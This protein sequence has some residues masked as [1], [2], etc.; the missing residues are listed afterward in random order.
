MAVPITEVMSK[1]R[2]IESFMLEARFCHRHTTER[3]GGRGG[4]VDEM[5]LSMG[6]GST[7]EAARQ[8]PVPVG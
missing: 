8:M 1:T 7:P 3:Q 5:C 2:K 4:Q 6:L